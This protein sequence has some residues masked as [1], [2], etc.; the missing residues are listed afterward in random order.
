MPLLLC[1]AGPDLEALHAMLLSKVP[2]AHQKYVRVLSS[3]RDEDKVWLYHYCAAF[4]LPSKP[5]ANFTETFGIVLAEKALSQ[6]SGPTLATR[7][8]YVGFTEQR[9]WR[10]FD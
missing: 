2:P 5:T 9:C 10:C 6:A 4:V 8:G 7:T 1:T 3:V